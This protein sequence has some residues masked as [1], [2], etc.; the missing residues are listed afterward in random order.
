MKTDAT[1]AHGVK[2]LACTCALLLACA[3][4]PE[5]NWHED[6]PELCSDGFDNDGDGQVDCF[7]V[8]C[9]YRFPG[10]CGGPTD[11]STD[12]PGD[13]SW[14]PGTDTTPGTT[15]VCQESYTTD[16][17]D[18]PDGWRE[19]ID[20]VD[21]LGNPAGSSCSRS[22]ASDWDC[23]ECGACYELTTGYRCLNY[24]V[25]AVDG[26]YCPLD[27]S[28]WPDYSH[29][30]ELGAWNGEGLDTYF[31]DIDGTYV[32]RFAVGFPDHPDFLMAIDTWDYDDTPVTGTFDLRRGYDGN[33]AT[34]YHCV[35][36]YTGCT[37]DSCAKVFFQA[38]GT[39]NFWSVGGAAGEVFSGVITDVPLIEVTMDPEDAWTSP[40]PGGQ[41]Y[42]IRSMSWGDPL[43]TES[44][45]SGSSQAGIS[46]S[47]GA[48]TA[49]GG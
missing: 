23:G 11:T 1:S 43:M 35:R 5:K 31:Y 6:S 39:G 42:I 24:D 15:P 47:S 9:S 12:D 17:T 10:L 21:S 33:F 18:C 25:Y 29:C 36:L 4:S 22:C 27:W 28:C 40:V 14:D 34:C 32:N 48:A 38:D 7:D 8:D 2:A 41:C 19:C 45:S 37:A 20:W 44:G 26:Y 16:C 13:T 30:I 46:P 49:A 3:C